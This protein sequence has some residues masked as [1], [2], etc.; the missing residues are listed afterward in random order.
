MSILIIH[1]EDNFNLKVSYG[2][3]KVAVLE[4]SIKILSEM[5]PGWLVVR[6]VSKGKIVRL[7]KEMNISDLRMIIITDF[8]LFQTTVC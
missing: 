6:K 8:P 7:Q 5:M 4:R 3:N 1:R 2:F